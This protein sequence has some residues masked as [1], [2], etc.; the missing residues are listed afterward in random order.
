MSKGPCKG[1]MREGCARVE[2]TLERGQCERG[3]RERGCT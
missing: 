1:T 2:G 3:V